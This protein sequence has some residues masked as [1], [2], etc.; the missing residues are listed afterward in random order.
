MTVDCILP[1]EMRL[2]KSEFQ[3]LWVITVRWTFGNIWT[4]NINLYLYLYLFI[5]CS[6]KSERN[7][8]SLMKHHIIC[9]RHAENYGNHAT[10]A[11]LSD[12]TRLQE[13]SVSVSVS[14]G[15]FGILYTTDNRYVRQRIHACT[16]FPRIW[17]THKCIEFC[18]Q[19]HVYC[20]HAIDVHNDISYIYIYI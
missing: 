7:S 17:E 12:M 4:I 6:S 11:I 5:Y 14:D 15:V 3:C 18:T 20:M 9:T 1:R 19:Y 16:S 10:W 2:W 8:V 13:V